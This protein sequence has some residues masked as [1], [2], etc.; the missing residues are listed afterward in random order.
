MLAEAMAA[1][2]TMSDNESDSADSDD[3]QRFSTAKSVGDEHPAA[4]AEVRL[5]PASTQPHTVLCS[6]CSARGG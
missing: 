2:M 4:S 6:D 3:M 1:S 5:Q